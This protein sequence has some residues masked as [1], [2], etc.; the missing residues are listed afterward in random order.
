MNLASRFCEANVFESVVGVFAAATRV[1]PDL[2]H[3]EGDLAAALPHVDDIGITQDEMAAVENFLG[4]ADTK[5]VRD[6]GRENTSFDPDVG[7]IF[8]GSCQS[9]L[10]ITEPI[11]V[12][13][14]DVGLVP[15]NQLVIEFAARQPAYE[16]QVPF[17]E[18]QLRQRG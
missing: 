10:A 3:G 5:N 2:E 7:N 4:P 8:A 11:A 16:I 17:E 15:R 14:K 18:I 6:A 1:S 13:S 9:L 12:K